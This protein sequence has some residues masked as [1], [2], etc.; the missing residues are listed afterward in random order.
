MKLLEKKPSIISILI[1][2]TNILILHMELQLKI[3][4]IKIQKEYFRHDQSCGY[5]R[6]QHI[7]VALNVKIID[8]SKKYN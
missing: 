5:L 8:F 2:K 4:D 7:T 3:I 1:Y 6:F